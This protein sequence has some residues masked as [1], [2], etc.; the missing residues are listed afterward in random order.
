MYVRR[1]SKAFDF[2]V[3][4]FFER[5]LNPTT[6]FASLIEERFG[7]SVRYESVLPVEVEPN[8]PKPTPD[9]ARLLEACNLNCRLLML[10]MFGAYAQSWRYY[11]KVERSTRVGLWRDSSVIHNF[12]GVRRFK[13]CMQYL[14]NVHSL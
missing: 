11:A 9:A 3:P 6:T 1:S 5:F 4:S 14:V 10:D 12:T 7:G 13:D 2:V 8:P